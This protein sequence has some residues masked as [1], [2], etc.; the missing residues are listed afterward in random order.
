[1]TYPGICSLEEQAD[2][3]N[4][5]PHSHNTRVIPGAKIHVLYWAAQHNEKMKQC[6]DNKHISD[7]IQCSL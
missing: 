3:Y 7:N 4:T 6:R 5:V 2:L 1:M